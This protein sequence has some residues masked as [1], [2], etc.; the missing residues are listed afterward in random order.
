M[1]NH[2]PYNIEDL[3]IELYDETEDFEISRLLLNFGINE[4]SIETQHRIKTKKG[5]MTEK[6]LE[7][8]R[9]KRRIRANH[10]NRLLRNMIKERRKKDPNWQQPINTSPHHIVDVG[11]RGGTRAKMILKGVGIDID[12]A[13]NGVF[14]PTYVKRTP[15]PDMPYAYAHSKVHTDV[16]YFNIT[17]RL[18]ESEGDRYEVE[19]ALKDIADDLVNGNFPV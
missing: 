14:L 2:I 17:E 13:I 7:E 1:T 3:F 18:A 4:Y 16:Y 15:H 19:E 12:D 5:F 10:T 6:E 9:K 8:E 11:K